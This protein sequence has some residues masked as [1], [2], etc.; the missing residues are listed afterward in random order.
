LL[1]KVNGVEI[2][3]NHAWLGF[4]ITNYWIKAITN[5]DLAQTYAITSF[6]TDGV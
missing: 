1:L 5:F 3:A 4:D 6:V 2:D